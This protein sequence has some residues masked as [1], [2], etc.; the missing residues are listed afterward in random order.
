[1]RSRRSFGRCVR[2]QVFV[3]VVLSSSQLTWTSRSADIMHWPM[4]P[5]W[6]RVS[7]TSVCSLPVLAPQDRSA[8]LIALGLD[9]ATTPD[10][11]Q[12]KRAFRKKVA[13]LHPDLQGGA[14]EDSEEF[15]AVLDAYAVLSGRRRV[16]QT[17]A[18]SGAMVWPPRPSEDLEAKREAEF[19][20]PGNWRWSQSGGYNPRDLNQVWDEIGYNPYTGEYREPQERQADEETWV[21]PPTWATSRPDPSPPPSRPRPTSPQ[22]LEEAAPEFRLEILPYL[23]VISVSL[24]FALAPEQLPWVSEEERERRYDELARVEELKA[25]QLEQRQLEEVFWRQNLK[26]M[27]TEELSG[28]AEAREEDEPQVKRVAGRWVIEDSMDEETETLN[29]R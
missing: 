17:T 16:R 19:S 3:A 1:M 5:R 20:R 7:R 26:K 21:E 27:Q 2:Q 15:M 8:A 12:V 23:A 29:S 25:R 9:P 18:K 22:E 11:T 10:A 14:A 28:L 13:L 4:L 24:Y 6:H